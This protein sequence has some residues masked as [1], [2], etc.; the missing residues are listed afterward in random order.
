M[1]TS[2][3]LVDNANNLGWNFDYKLALVTPDE[4]RFMRL[5]FI[6]NAMIQYG[7]DM[8]LSLCE[9]EAKKWLLS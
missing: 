7:Y 9:N 5:S 8:K 2:F 6:E 3:N 4:D 1:D